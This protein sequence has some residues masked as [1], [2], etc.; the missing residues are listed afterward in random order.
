MAGLMTSLATL[1]VMITGRRVILVV[2]L[3]LSRL[4]YGDT[5]LIGLPVYLT[6]H[7]QSILNA[8]A[9]L[10]YHLRSADHITDALATFHW[11][12][13]PEQITYKIAVLTSKVLHGSALRHL[14]PLIPLSDQPG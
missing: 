12:C 10:I 1:V 13:V 14:G 2:T 5:V 3:V 6:H 7:L 9:R 4:D 11:L 8:V